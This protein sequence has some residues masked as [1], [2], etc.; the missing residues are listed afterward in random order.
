MKQ[1]CLEC[2]KP[3][4]A[5]NYQHKV[6]SKECKLARHRVGSQ[7]Y[8]NK[9][10]RNTRLQGRQERDRLRQLWGCRPAP[11]G[12][13]V[14]GKKTVKDGRDIYLKLLPK[15]DEFGFYNIFDDRHGLTLSLAGDCIATR[16]GRNC[17]VEVTCALAHNIKR[18]KAL[19]N[20]LGLDLYAVFVR[21]DF[22]KIIL[23]RIDVMGL[24][25]SVNLNQTKIKKCLELNEQLLVDENNE[26]V[27]LSQVY[28]PSH[29]DIEEEKE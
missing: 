9:D 15:L 2:K 17:I 8:K 27:P 4:E 24:S 1:I 25:K 18:H 22:T 12:K 3:F 13:H 20:R 10:R 23:K 28:A 6:C 5:R 21:R 26:I 16:N 11:D 29:N 7:K 19:C 14:N